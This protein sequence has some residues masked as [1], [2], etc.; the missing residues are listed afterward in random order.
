MLGHDMPNPLCKHDGAPIPTLHRKRDILGAAGDQ[1]GF[2]MYA[3]LLDRKSL[4]LVVAGLLLVGLLLF[5]AGLMVGAR[6]GFAT[7]GPEPSWAPGR[8]EVA[9]TATPPS[10]PGDLAIA[11]SDDLAI[12]P[13]EPP[14][15]ARSEE[16]PSPAP[17]PPEPTP[18]PTISP[19]PPLAPPPPVTPPPS[20]E[21]AP[22]PPSPPPQQPQPRTE[23]PPPADAPRQ[24]YTVQVG[25]Y[26]YRANAERQVAKLES[27]QPYVEVIEDEGGD[28]LYTVRIG[29]YESR[30]RA[31]AMAVTIERELGGPSATDEEVL[32]RPILQ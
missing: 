16:P 10:S 23:P 24:L 17:P 27:Y 14:A 8:H 32:V 30:E 6:W 3:F 18:A 9:S 1:A 22:P 13:F 28:L 11:G 7:I 15:K 21:P 26:R 12:A 2:E 4:L 31:A 5:G 25:A 19:P 20:R 29:S